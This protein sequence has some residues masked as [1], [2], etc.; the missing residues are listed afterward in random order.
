M[1]SV[2]SK[3]T[4]AKNNSST[5]D[6]NSSVLSVAANDPAAEQ[7]GATFRDHQQTAGWWP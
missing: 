5:V 1:R 7:I 2:L 6:D 4:T 3:E